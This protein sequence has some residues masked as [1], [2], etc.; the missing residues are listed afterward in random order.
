M[1]HSYFFLA[2]QWW[3]NFDDRTI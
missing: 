1:N 2:G 3:A